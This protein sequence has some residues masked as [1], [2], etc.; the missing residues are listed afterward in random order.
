MQLCEVQLKFVSTGALQEWLQ[1]Y[2]RRRHY[3]GLV[4]PIDLDGRSQ[5]PG[6]QKLWILLLTMILWRLQDCVDYL[7]KR[8]NFHEAFFLVENFF[9]QFDSPLNNLYWLAL[10]AR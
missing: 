1:G 2:F 3:P 5:G 6:N 8:L 7:A 9:F 4:R 10:L